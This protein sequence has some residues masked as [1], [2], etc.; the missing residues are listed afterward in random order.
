MAKEKADA[1]TQTDN[2]LLI[3]KANEWPGAFGAFKYSS[4]AIIINLS[5]VLIIIGISILANILQEAFK[6]SDDLAAL[7]AVVMFVVSGILAVT[8]YIVYLNGAKGKRIEIGDA[9]KQTLSLSLLINMF[10]LSIMV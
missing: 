9:L 3:S 8:S 4:R 7:Y 2:S 6:S 5:T 1:S 10:V